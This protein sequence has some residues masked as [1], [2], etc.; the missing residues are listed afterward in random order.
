MDPATLEQMAVEIARAVYDQLKAELAAERSKQLSLGVPDDVPLMFYAGLRERIRRVMDEG[1]GVALSFNEADH[2]RGQPGHPSEFAKKSE[3]GGASVPT[4]TATEKTNKKEKA[5]PPKAPRV[6]EQKP[7]SKAELAKATHKPS[8]KAKQDHAKANQDVVAKGIG[9]QVVQDNAPTDVIVK[10]EAGVHGV[11]VKTMLDND[12]DRI[13][14]NK[15]AYDRKAKWCAETGST[16]HVSATD[17][18]DV[19]DGGANAHQFSGNKLYYKR[20]GGSFALSGMHPCKDQAEF[21][22][23][24]DLPDDQLPEK[25]RPLPAW[26]ARVKLARAW[27]AKGVNK[28]TTAIAAQQAA[29]GVES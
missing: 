12:N 11:E 8:T 15:G 17:D 7:S 16:L 24:M 3:G 18:R 5:K 21:R 23:M 10:H 9:G 6:P 4:K 1:D 25:A 13:K 22:A 19:F 27:K 29:Q 2:P 20:G 26:Q 28:S 14:M